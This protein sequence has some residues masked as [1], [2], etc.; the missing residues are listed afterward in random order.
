MGFSPLASQDSTVDS[1]LR[2]VWL[3]V[4]IS[5]AGGAESGFKILI[6]KCSIMLVSLTLNT[7]VDDSREASSDAICCLA[8]IVTLT[9]LLDI[10]Q[11]QSPINDLD[12]G[13]DLGVELSVVLRLIS[14]DKRK[15]SLFKAAAA[16]TL[17]FM[18]DSRKQSSLLRHF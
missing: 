8:Q 9:S 12:I 17:N 16:I 4:L 13:L 6:L 2:A 3:R 10:F 1:P 7:D 14:C 18:G 15:T 5:N 11:H